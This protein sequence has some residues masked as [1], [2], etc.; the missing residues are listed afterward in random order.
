MPYKNLFFWLF[1]T[2]AFYSAAE[3][4][5]ER[6][7]V[8]ANR[9]QQ[10]TS[11]VNASLSILDKSLI[12]QIN[13]QH[14]SQVA[15]F[16]PG[17][18]I[19]R[20]NGQEHLTAIRSPVLT[21]A[22][23]CG[24]FFMAL[25]GINL[26]APGFCNANQLF[27][28]NSEQAQRI[29]ILRGPASTLY[30]S[31]ALHGVINIISPAAESSN[32]SLA[33]S[34]GAY[35]TYRLKSDSSWQLSD[36]TQR[37][38]FNIAD[39]GGYQQDSGYSQQKLTF[40]SQQR[41]GNWQ[42]TSLLSASHLNQETAGFV[43]GYKIY[44]D[45]QARRL[46]PNPEAFRNA[47]SVLAYS[48]FEQDSLSIT[49]Y[50]RWNQMTFLQHY[51]PW[52]ALEEN[53][54]KSLGLQ[55]QKIFTAFSAQWISGIDLDITQAELQETQAQP[56][57]PSIPQ[58]AHYDYDVLAQ[59]IG[60]YLQANWQLGDIELSLG[61]RAESMK[62]DYDN[63]LTDGSAC[64]PQVAL[65]RFSRPQDQEVSFSQFSPEALIAYTIHSNS[66]VYAK[67][68]QGFRAPQATEL[69]RLQNNQT[70]TDIE[71]VSMDALEVGFRYSGTQHSIELSLYDMEKEN[72]IISDTNRQTVVGG[73]TE[74]R[75]FEASWRWQA[76]SN[77]SISSQFSVQ[78]HTY[79]NDIAISN[80]SIKGNLIDTSPK[81]LASLLADWK[82]L[83]NFSTQL[84]LQYM[85]SYF[86]DPENTAEYDG[87]TLVD[88]SA[89]Y[90]ISE[91][92]S[93]QG[94]LFNLLDEDYA[95]RADFAF[96]NYRYFVGQP[97][98]LFISVKLRY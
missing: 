21:G 55:L 74:H 68:S 54:H 84:Q 64:D 96:G 32:D 75:G 34:A 95:E 72:V 15:A 5:V 87:H 97:R 39:H 76:L 60:G 46:N 71:E 88:L 85:D 4:D 48:K 3:D 12:E 8:T 43:Q 86:L 51:L 25:D 90:D 62:Y 49:P 26:R 17:T 45:E 70:L 31:N 10:T 2:S 23:S 61:A 59:Q 6:I 30:G 37:L 47:E 53:A 79:Q 7:S 69:F 40:V 35:D 41:I 58:G 91:S 16:S 28:V 78:R 77:L 27:D 89:R 29:E 11:S 57:S 56:F 93:I 73:N 38:L 66:R 33:F 82:V 24:A 13:A 9:N 22:G 80:Q 63:K 42:N 20:G 92:I 44:Q 19:S 36:S 98:R 1:L 83:D 65:C 94:N 67:F 81:K 50:L 52:Q 14:I 18:W